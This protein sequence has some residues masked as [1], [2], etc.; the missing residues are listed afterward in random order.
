LPLSRWLL[1][2]ANK[3]VAEA[4]AALEAYRFDEYA[5]ACY[6]FTWGSFCDWFLEFAKPVF[7]GP[8]GAE[9][10]EIRGVAQHVLGTILRLLHPAMPFVT[11]E[12]WDRF[13][14]GAE[15]SL[16]GESWPVAVAVPGAEEARAELDWVVALISEVRSIRS[17][18]GVAPK[19]K[20]R[21]FLFPSVETESGVR[22]WAERYEPF[23]SRLAGLSLVDVHSQ[24][25]STSA[26]SGAE[27]SVS[28]LRCDLRFD[29]E[30]DLEAVKQ[31][32]FK[33]RATAEAEA[34]KVQAKLSN[35]DF[36]SRAKPEVVE[37]NQERLANFQAEMARLDA[38]IARL[39]G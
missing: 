1:D 31:R 37:E 17:D 36:V 8:D 32:F 3:A 22:V 21:L 6:R 2:A 25:Q 26:S 30:V 16:I 29:E 7:N 10:E 34:A 13:G 15:C 28:G 4:T 14:Y 27:F 19:L 39:G 20:A 12:L 11:E 35:A 5:A 24:A 9:K 33:A 18:F 23:L 38:A